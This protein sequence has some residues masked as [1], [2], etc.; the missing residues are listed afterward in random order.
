[1]VAFTQSY[2][3]FRNKCPPPPNNVLQELKKK[4]KKKK[5]NQ[6][7]NEYRKRPTSTVS[8]NFNY[9][10]K[11]KKQLFK[12]NCNNDQMVDNI[13][14]MQKEKGK[15]QIILAMQI[16]TFKCN[17]DIDYRGGIKQTWK[18]KQVSEETDWWYQ[19]IAKRIITT[20]ER[21]SQSFEKKTG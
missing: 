7:T 18:S 1:M 11:K 3:L 19:N 16:K 21:N 10:K 9:K 2:R 14:Q 20:T 13:K 6:L 8:N 5:K 15:K 12:V 17:V 4:K